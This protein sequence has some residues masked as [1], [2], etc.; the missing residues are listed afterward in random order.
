MI[1]SSQKVGALAY[2]SANGNGDYKLLPFGMPRIPLKKAIN[3]FYKDLIMES[4]K[5]C[6]NFLYF[7][8]TW[9]GP[10]E[11][12]NYTFHKCVIGTERLPQ[13]M[14]EGFYKVILKSYVA[15]E[16]GFEF[17]TRVFLL[18]H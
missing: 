2:R 10:L 8:K 11:A 5:N 4:L 18:D 6:S 1:L 9:E 12:K 17:E 14:P 15:I 7:K 13:Y 16:L 3:T